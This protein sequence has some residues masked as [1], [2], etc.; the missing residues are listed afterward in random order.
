MKNKIIFTAVLLFVQ[1]L[2]IGAFAAQK[3]VLIVTGM[4]REVSIAEGEGII[5]V[6]SAASGQQLRDALNKFDF[7]AVR[8]V[9]SF[10]VAGGLHPSL[11]PGDLAIASKVVSDTN[12]WATSPEIMR[13]LNSRFSGNAMPVKAVSVYA[14]DAAGKETNAQLRQRTG[15]DL[16]DTESHVAAEFAA[17]HN[18]PF[19]VVRTVSDSADF[20]LPPAALIPLLPNGQP[21]V[22]AV[23]ESLFENP[24]QFPDLVRLAA[25]TEKA[26][27]TL[28]KVRRVTD[29]ND[30]AGTPLDAPDFADQLGDRTGTPRLPASLAEKVA[31]FEFPPGHVSISKSGRIFM[32]AGFQDPQA[33]IRVIELKDGKQIPFPEE[34]YQAQFKSV[35]GTYVDQK[36]RLWILD[37]GNN[38]FSRKPRLFGYD[39]NTGKEIENYEFPA[40]VAGL[41]SMLNDLVV[42]PARELI[43]IS[44]P[45]PVFGNAGILVFD[46]KK[47]TSRRLLDRHPSVSAANYRIYVE[48]KP[49][50]V[51]GLVHPK[52]G[53]DGLALDPTGTWLYYAAFNG[54]VL[55]RIPLTALADESL[56]KDQVAAT[57]QKVADITMTDGIFVDD[58]QRVYLSDVEH[59]AV[60][61]LN[62]DGKLETIFKD[63]EFRWPTGFTPS[64]DGF[65]YFNCNA[66]HQ[67]TLKSRRTIQGFG[68][69]YL[70]RFR[71]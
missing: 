49:F 4:A 26:Y 48:G 3:P 21:D 30:F 8:A 65:L 32:D 29:S 19:S 43:Y 42:D 39:I 31:Q 9:V 50:T 2:S 35:H 59:S 5:T 46:M 70:Y 61:R 45:G 36:D 53:I 58:K 24:E 37:H 27:R 55:H 57:L 14:H 68:P 69:Y 44:E 63:P 33:K 71:P 22:F 10:G 13:A 7:T 56:T 6:L 20:T 17:A 64:P 23:L 41:G 16:V 62:A 34:K 47:R 28:K 11:K 54:G 40:K 1:T 12:E 52:F 38:G 15:A 60:V 18:L 25:N 51:I 66:I 67:V